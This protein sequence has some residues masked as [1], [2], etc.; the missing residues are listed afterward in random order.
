[1]ATDE[2]RARLSKPVA[3][4]PGHLVSAFDCGRPEL[5]DWLKAWGHRAIEADTAR[6]FVVC[7][8]AKT[9]VGYF[10]LAAGAADHTDRGTGERAPRSL[11][12]NSPDPI[13][14]IVL[15][16]LAVDKSEQG[17]GLGAALVREGMRR[18]A[19]ASR[20]VGARALLVHALDD[21]LVAYYESI[22]FRRFNPASRTLYLPMSTIRAG[23]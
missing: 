3:L 10:S 23:L 20:I 21:A 19:Q 9:V 1:V 11:R 17:K 22:G 2:R 5:T 13:P 16:R 15:A 4:K 12:Q 6:T 18:T 14:V 8:G 7:R